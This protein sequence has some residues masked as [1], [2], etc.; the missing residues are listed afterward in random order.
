LELELVALPQR[1]CW[2]EKRA[3]TGVINRLEKLGMTNLEDHIKFEIC[4]TR[5]LPGHASN[6]KGGKNNRGF[7]GIDS[8]LSPD[9]GYLP[10][11][12]A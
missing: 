3:R 9:S 6:C 12:N 5:L 10:I 4:S 11:E 8:G 1:S 2:P 7:Q